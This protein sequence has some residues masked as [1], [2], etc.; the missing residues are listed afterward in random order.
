MLIQFHFTLDSLQCC[1]VYR[2]NEFN[3]RFQ[4]LYLQKKHSELQ[5]SEEAKFRTFR[6]NNKLWKRFA[7]LYMY[8]RMFDCVGVF[9][10]R[11][12]RRAQSTNVSVIRSIPRCAESRENN[13]SY[14]TRNLESQVC[15]HTARTEVKTKKM[16]RLRAIAQWHISIREMPLLHDL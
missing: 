6:S 2:T 4:I 15:V 10:Y 8:L 9:F 7:V 1:T 14:T 16:L 11:S 5:C 13:T 12:S 3:I